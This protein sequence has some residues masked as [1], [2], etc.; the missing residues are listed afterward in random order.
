MTRP[1][2]FKYVWLEFKARISKRRR[3][4]SKILIFIFHFAF[5]VNSQKNYGH[6]IARSPALSIMKNAECLRHSAK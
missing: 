5:L 1:G 6:V 4:R 3:L 2:N